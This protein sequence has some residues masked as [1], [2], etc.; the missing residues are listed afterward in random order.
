MAMVGDGLLAA[1][2]WTYK[3]AWLKVSGCYVIICKC[4][5]AEHKATIICR[6][7]WT[8]SKTKF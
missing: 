5:L 3:L 6:E 1:Y 8:K 2:R 4:G 7:I